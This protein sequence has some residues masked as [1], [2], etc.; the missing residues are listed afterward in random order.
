M[1]MWTDSDKYISQVIDSLVTAYDNSFAF[2]MDYDSQVTWWSKEALALFEFEDEYCNDG[3]KLLEGFIHQDDLAEYHETFKDRLEGK[4]TD[5]DFYLRVFHDDYYYMYGFKTKIIDNANGTP[6]Y[7]V[8]VAMNQNILPKI[9]PI[10][11][12][13][14]ATKFEEDLLGLLKNNES[15]CVM[16]ISLDHFNNIHIAYGSTF[17]RSVIQ[18][19]AMRLI[20]AM[21]ARTAVYKLEGEQFVFVLKNYGK[22]ELYEFENGIRQLLSE[23]IYIDNI[24]ISLKIS[25]GAIMIDDYQSEPAAILSRVHYALNHSFVKHQGD[26]IIFNEEVSINKNA[27]LDLMRIIHQSVRAGCEGFFLQYQPI[28]SSGT[29]IVTGAEALVRWSLEPYGTVPPGMF[30][31]WMEDDPSMYVLGNFI[32]T[33]ALT[34]GK[35]FLDRMPGFFLNVNLSARQIENHNFKQALKDI[36]DKTGFP[37]ANLCLE[38]TE[39]CKDLPLETLRDVVDFI[40]LLGAKVAIDDYGTGS[41]SSNIIIQVPMDEIKIDMSFVR[42]ITSEPKK[43]NMVRGI[44]ELANRSGMKSCIEGVEDKNIENYLRT[45]GATWFQGY[46][47]SKPISAE[48]VLLILAGDCKLGEEK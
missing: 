29:G 37:A 2:V 9:D 6:K 5:Y 20:Y 32:L 8:C 43:Q 36:L 48:N 10:T 30:I 11:D 46:H 14:S 45:F 1:K 33:K 4:N 28:V 12:L 3:F 19:V 17:A 41:A 44:V 16:A 25:A 47:Y 42:N 23:D 27:D 34:D 13:Y 31:E 35:K 18:E 24:N 15:F 7:F 39:R 21:N 26:L 38:L 22:D 40:H